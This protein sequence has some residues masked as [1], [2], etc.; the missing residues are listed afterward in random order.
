MYHVRKKYGVAGFTSNTK[1]CPEVAAAYQLPEKPKSA[2]VVGVPLATQV[3][4]ASR[5]VSGI[6]PL[7]PL[8]SLNAYVSEPCVQSVNASV[9]EPT[10]V[11]AVC[12]AA[13]KLPPTFR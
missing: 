13:S 11:A 6:A 2:F 7:R 4:L 5:R 10:C 8:P 12:G 3:T 9:P 1:P